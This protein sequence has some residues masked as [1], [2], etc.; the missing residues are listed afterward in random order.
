MATSPALPECASPDL[1]AHTAP[2]PYAR[3]VAKMAKQH[4]LLSVHWELTYRCNETCTHCYLD[5]FQPNATV[6]GEL[7]TAQ[8]KSTLDQLAAM[9]VLNITFSG[10]EILVHRDFFEIAAYARRK[11]FAIRLMSNGLLIHERMADRIVALLAP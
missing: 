2:N 7:A 11:R 4:R 9:G 6:A 1:T 8:I 3:I 5:V 10:G